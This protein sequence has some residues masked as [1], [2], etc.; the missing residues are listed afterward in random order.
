MA[1]VGGVR[2]TFRGKDAGRIDSGVLSMQPRTQHR[3]V[4]RGPTAQ[5]LF[6]QTLLG[7]G[8]PE[9]RFERPRDQP[10]LGRR[11]QHLLGCPERRAGALECEGTEGVLVEVAVLAGGFWRHGGGGEGVEWRGSVGGS[12]ERRSYGCHGADQGC[13]RRENA[14]FPRLSIV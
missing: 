1:F 14:Q 10:R 12:D 11:C 5:P 4:Q 13:A 6:R 3:G 7:V 8:R 9:V 2:W